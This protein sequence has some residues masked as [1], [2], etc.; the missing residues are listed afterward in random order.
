VR[1]LWQTR[2]G[3][4]VHAYSAK[5]VFCTK[6]LIQLSFASYRFAFHDGRELGAIVM[7]ISI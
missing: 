4:H 5:H 7:A 3:D 2:S 6:A 1:D